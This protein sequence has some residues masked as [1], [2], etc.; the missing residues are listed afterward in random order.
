VHVPSLTLGRRS[1]SRRGVLFLGAVMAAAAVVVIVA[2][3]TMLPRPT[4][5]VIAVA[6]PSPTATPT[7]RPT[8]TPTAQP[9]P[10]PTPVPTPSPTISPAD[11]L[12]GTDGR[13][14]VLLLGSDYRPA[15]PG[16][17]T[18]VMMVVSIDPTT[19]AVAAASIPRDTTAFP[20]SSK[21]TYN[22]KVNG[23]YQSLIS[24]YGQPKAA[25]KMKRI[26]GAGIGVEIDAYAV[27]GFEGV[28]Q[29]V[30]AVGGVDVTLAKSVS[31]PE[32]WVSPHHQGVYFPAGHN[33]LNGDRALIF[34]RTRKGDN[35]FERARRQQLLVAGAVDAVRDRGL[36]K[37]PALVS[38]GKRF[39][40]TDLP[41]A[42]APELFAIVAKA[43]IAHPT[44]V[45]FGP[46][47][48][49]S[50]A[51]GTSF[52]LKLGEVRRW[53]A[54]WMAPVVSATVSE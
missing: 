5:T 18:D 36:S 2:V 50:A 53:T 42:A 9:T 34:A 16:N 17:R 46:T 20:T 41:L 24:R 14:T 48:W 11:K 3:A 54:K 32:Y 23:L 37:L 29:L 7:P 47:K 21:G 30:N 12:L 8:A 26:V 38:I 28:R 51:S 22:A 31:D 35:D 25:R 10:S 40:K 43:D 39:V 44:G 49:A 13:L 52:K 4:A 19:G 1:L 33:H 15:H 27:V 6:S 45:V